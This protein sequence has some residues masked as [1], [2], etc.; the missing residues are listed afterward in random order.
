MKRLEILC[1]DRL[2]VVQEVVTLISQA[3]LD[4]RGIELGHQRLFVRISS[5]PDSSVNINRQL[6]N[7]SGVS[8]VAEIPFMPSEHE[9]Q[10]LK[11]LMDRFPEAAVSVSRSGTILT[12]NQRFAD[13]RQSLGDAGSGIDSIIE[14]ELLQQTI[15]Q[16]EQGQTPNL[17]LHVN[18]RAL[19]V[20]AIASSRD[21]EAKQVNTILLIFRQPAEMVSKLQHWNRDKSFTFDQLVIESEAMQRVCHDAQKFASL[22]EPLLI[23]GETGT[24]KEMFARATHLAR[25]SGKPFLALNCASLPDSAAENELFGFVA[26][27]AKTTKPG[28]IELAEGGTLYFDEI[29]EMSPYLQVKLLRFL[30]TGKFRKVGSE[31]EVAINV[32]VIA[33]SQK[34]LQALGK[35]GAFREDLY[36]RLNVLAIKLPP[37]RRR[38]AD[39]LPLARFFIN[40]GCSRLQ[41]QPVTMS[42][43]A[44][45]ALLRYNWPGNVRELENIIFRALSKTNGTTLSTRHLQMPL[46]KPLAVDGAGDDDVAFKD[47]VK[48]YERQ[49]LEYLYP[50]YPSTRKL[51][52]RL[53]MSHTAVAN[54]L[55]EYG[56]EVE[57]T[58]E[59]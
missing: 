40:L 13:L 46:L 37:L 44:E 35:Q 1:D 20:E 55:K 54:K 45:L 48:S 59:L 34:N 3:Q 21:D 36:Y 50:I 25:A 28:L 33:S 41:R 42:K 29:G 32:K 17:T 6:L 47:L 18:E 10:E 26:N 39:I 38:R 9:H 11:L 23:E 58:K 15:G 31:Q 7:I 2:G 12:A 43:R 30:E 5:Q 52:A 49:L 4:L 56:I 57:Q 8:A 16:L 19:Y 27:D 22:S 51:A 53:Q 24:G 14:P